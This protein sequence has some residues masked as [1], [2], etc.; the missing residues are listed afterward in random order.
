MKFTFPNIFLAAENRIRMAKQALQVSIESA[1]AQMIASISA[2]PR[3]VLTMRLE[4]YL[5]P[6]PIP[7]APH[8][9]SINSKRSSSNTRSSMQQHLH[10]TPRVAKPG[11]IVYSAR[12]SPIVL[13]QARGGGLAAAA[14][15]ESSDEEGEEPSF[16][17]AS[18][19][20]SSSESFS[21]PDEAAYTAQVME[22]ERN[23]ILSSEGF[24]PRS[25]S[26][27]HRSSS[28]S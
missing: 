17:T 19:K 16:D 14:A 28:S 18:D 7:T 4:E 15:V 27:F 3:H 26:M 23:R 11:E 2:F 8:S 1:R 5:N 12:G 10:K 21:L 24:F 22:Q 6:T 25:S 20:S 13:L 9:K